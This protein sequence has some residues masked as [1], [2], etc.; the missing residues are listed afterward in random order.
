MPSNSLRVLLAFLLCVCFS[1]THDSI[2][3]QQDP[4]Q[5]AYQLTVNGSNFARAGNFQAAIDYLRQAY[6]LVPSSWDVNYFLGYTYEKMKDYATAESWYIQAHKLNPARHE[7]LLGIARSYYMQNDFRNALPIFEQLA[8][9]H[10]ATEIGYP[11]YLALA[12]CYAE[13]GRTQDFDATIQ[14][15]FALRSTDPETL[16]FAAQEMDHLGQFDKALKYYTEYLKTFPNVPDQAAID[17]RIYLLTYQQENAELLK[18]VSEGFKLHSDTEDLRDFVQIVDPKKRGISNTALSQVF[19]G[20]SEIP[21]TY[22]HQLEADGFKV[23]VTPDLLDAM[24]ELAGQTPRGYRDGATWHSTNGITDRAGKRIVIAEQ[25][26]TPGPDGKP[27]KPPLDRTVQ[28][29]FGHA[30]DY[31]AGLKRF[32]ATAE[33]PF[34]AISHGKQF[35]DAYAKDSAKVPESLRS[36]LAY[37]LQPGDAGKEE[38]FAQMFVLFFGPRPEPGSPR[39]SFQTAFPDVIRELHDARRSDPEFDRLQALYEGKFQD[40][41]LTPEQRVQKLL[42]H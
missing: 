11:G 16:R 2:R 23:V 15:A 25:C 42:E 17:K 30:Y 7:A 33:N 28:H 22:R 34:P 9:Q 20:L 41:I 10:A 6:A 35:S 18:E 1:A 32:G 31:Y 39:E 3:A 29:E 21:R 24:P 8:A 5:V 38:L 36:K 14:K 12:K 27:I 40:N 37:Y 19:L 26:S 13:T 4:S